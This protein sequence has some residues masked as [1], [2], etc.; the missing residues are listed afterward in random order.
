MS[1]KLPP[2]ALRVLAPLLLVAAPAAALADPPKGF[3]EHVEA[4]R[5]DS[6]APGIAIAIVEHGKTT[7]A[8]GW[9]VR[10]LGDP[11]K[12]D[13]HTIF[14]T[15]STGKAFTTAAIATLVD[16]GKLKWDDKVIDHIPWFRMYD[17]WVTNEMTVRDLLVHHS[18]LGLGAGDLMY[19]PRTSIGRKE[20]VV[21]WAEPTEGTPARRAARATPTTTC[22]TSSPAS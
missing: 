22:S 6:G 13:E 11:G 20:T 10:K 17:P 5:R 19:V 14:P 9:G 18:G 8:R 3:V 7:L 15:G 16:Q 12:V 21:E 1:F 2:D 4:L